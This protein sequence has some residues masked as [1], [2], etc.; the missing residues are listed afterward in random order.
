MEEESKKEGRKKVNEERM[1]PFKQE[2]ETERTE[3]N[4]G[5]KKKELKK[6]SCN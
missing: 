1:D 2:M 6:G 4:E 5:L 3:R